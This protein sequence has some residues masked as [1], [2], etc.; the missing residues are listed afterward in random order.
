LAREAEALDTELEQNQ[1]RLD[2]LQV[3][4][5]GISLKVPRLARSMAH[6]LTPII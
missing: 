2:L 6:T 4:E 3:L 5:H 1:Q